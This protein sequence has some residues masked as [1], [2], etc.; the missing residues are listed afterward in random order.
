MPEIDFCRSVDQ[1]R[2]V[3]GRERFAEHRKDK[4]GVGSFMSESRTIEI[5]MIAVFNEN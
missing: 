3:F 5:T 1:S 2:D 4:E